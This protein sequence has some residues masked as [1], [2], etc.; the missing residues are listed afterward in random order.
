MEYF[1]RRIGKKKADNFTTRL[2]PARMDLTLSEIFELFMDV[3]KTEG[4]SKITIRDH[5]THFQ[6]FC[7]FLE[8]D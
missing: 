2:K 8:R 1:T 7:D 3:K 5:Y 4:L 6:Y